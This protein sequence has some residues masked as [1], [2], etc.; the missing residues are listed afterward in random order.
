MAREDRSWGAASSRAVM[1]GGMLM[2]TRAEHSKK[3]VDLECSEG[4]NKVDGDQGRGRL[5]GQSNH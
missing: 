4:G 5:P 3:V 2:A 1:V